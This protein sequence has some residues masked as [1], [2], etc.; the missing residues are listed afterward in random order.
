MRDWNVVGVM[1]I[2]DSLWNMFVAK[3]Y[4][5]QLNGIGGW[6]VIYENDKRNTKNWQ[7]AI[8]NHQIVSLC[9]L[10][11][12][13]MMTIWRWFGR[14]SFI[15]IS[16]LKENT[17]DIYYFDATTFENT[18]LQNI[19]RKY[20]FLFLEAAAR[21]FPL[22][23]SEKKQII[24]SIRAFVFPRRKVSSAKPVCSKITAA[25]FFGSATPTNSFGQIIW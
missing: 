19:I 3:V 21:I 8:P 20:I 24:N 10:S 18:Y 5:M 15:L 22:E 12:S 17:V 7:N 13:W 11:E 4:R 14:F 1:S 2:F 16:R 25:H 9:S 6:H 23:S